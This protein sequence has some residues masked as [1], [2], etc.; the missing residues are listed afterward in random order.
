M[1]PLETLVATK[2]P[3]T[4]ASGRYLLHHSPYRCFF[5]Y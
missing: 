4:H 2:S 1:K 5:H 3:L